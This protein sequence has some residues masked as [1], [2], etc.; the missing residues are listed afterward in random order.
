MIEV[1]LT[2]D[3]LPGVDLNVYAAWAKKAIAT[4]LNAPGV[5]EFRANRSLLGTPLIRSTSVWKTAADWGNFVQSP[6]WNA[7]LAEM[8]AFVT[9]PRVEI[10]GPSPLV[11]EPLRPVKQ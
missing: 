3:F 10:W 8:S 1:H 9:P 5:V 11:P 6:E 2:Y 4:V 7:L